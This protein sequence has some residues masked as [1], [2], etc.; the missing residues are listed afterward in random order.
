LCEIG[1]VKARWNNCSCAN[2]CPDAH[3]DFSGSYRRAYKSA[4]YSRVGVS[5]SR[6]IYLAIDN[7]TGPYVRDATRE[8]FS[9]LHDPIGH[10]GASLHCLCERL[11]APVMGVLE[12][13]S[14]SFN[15][16]AGKQV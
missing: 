1:A 8:L 12:R 9:C 10:I 16:Q 3:D 6:Y 14:N 13:F 11:R 15:K 2:R 5:Q 7:V 4:S